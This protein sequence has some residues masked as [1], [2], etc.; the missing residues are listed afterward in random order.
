MLKYT[1][2]GAA[3]QIC[4]SN[5]TKINNGPTMGHVKK[6]PTL[7]YFG[8]ARVK[9]YQA[10]LTARETPASQAIQVHL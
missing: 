2:F 9:S 3:F 8:A 1:T 7:H 10:Q 5:S 6:R 4:D